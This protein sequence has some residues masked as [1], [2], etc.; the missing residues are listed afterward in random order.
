MKNIIKKSIIGIIALSITAQAS[1]SNKQIDDMVKKLNYQEN[2]K[3]STDIKDPFG[4]PK[5]KATTIKLI[6][7]KSNK[8]VIPRKK[9]KKVEKKIII[10][11]QGLIINKALINN[12]TYEKGEYFHD[13]QIVSITPNKLFLKQNDFIFVI[14]KGSSKII[15]KEN[16]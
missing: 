15:I 12:K 6:K 3:I 10:N 11:F 14:E 2:T 5:P 9:I 1:F 8:K 4:Y 16:K 7:A 13:A